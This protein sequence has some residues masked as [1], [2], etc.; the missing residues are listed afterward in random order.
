MLFSFAF[1][2]ILILGFVLISFTFIYT[3]NYE[4][5]VIAENNRFAAMIGG[6]LYS[7]MDRSYHIVEELAFNTDVKS[8]QT[9]SQTPVFVSC[10]ERNP[11]FELIYAQGMDGMQT[12]RSSGALGNRKNRWWFTQM[13]ELKKPFISESYYSV[14]TN[15]PCASVFYPITVNNEMTGIMGGDIK[16]SALQD[17]IEKSSEAGSWAFILDGKGVVAAHPKT[18]Y[19]EELYSYFKMTRTITIKNERGEPLKDEKG[20]IVTAEEPFQVSDDY[21][22]AI[23]NMTAGKSGWAKVSEEGGVIYISYLPVAMNGS[24]DPW[25]VISVK[26]YSAVT[27]QRNSIIIVIIA[28]GLVVALAS[29]VIVFLTA[30]GISIP[31][32]AVHS[33]LEKIG[34]GDL[35]GS[36][37]VKG[38]GEINDMMR[39]L[40]GARRNMSG[41]I[42]AIKETSASLLS[43]GGE[44]SKV[45]REFVMVI[46][47][48]SAGAAKALSESEEGAHSAGKT[49]SSI[50]EIIASIEA[51]SGSIEKQ[52]LTVSRSASSI[53]TFTSSISS[54]T[55]SLIR[56]EKNIENL[57]LVSEKGK[58]GLLEVSNNINEV[59]KE[60]EGLLEINAVIQTIASQT[61]LLSMNA[62]IEAAHAGESGK[63]FAVVADEIRKL[64]ES[65]S[66]QAKSVAGSLKKMREALI[67]ISNSTGNVI[68]NFNGMDKAAKTV[69]FQEKSIQEAM[70]SQETGASDISEAAESLKSVTLEV[71]MNSS[72]MLQESRKVRENGRNLENSAD[73]IRDAIGAINSGMERIQNA[74]TLIQEIT[75]KNKQNIET[76]S[77]DVSKFKI[78]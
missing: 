51:L 8:M 29:L 43:V 58:A 28:S 10:L 65:S 64:A 35:T 66:T 47:D 56:N 44:L 52:A 78:E 13:E 68:T 74:I 5:Q 71:E 6:E 16:L 26:E 14:S 18:S 2:I 25:Y 76:L 7:F 38:S 22:A 53:E 4:K 30:R 50:T 73:K 46:E 45:T 70:K 77:E 67:K 41:L 27:K 17:L 40:N 34:A 61:N 55:S 1:I 75:I 20:G 49:N 60:S 54:I 59:A 57:K 69:A 32:N 19:L 62:A 9:A 23:A 42:Q 11:Y 15:M 63:G 48:V 37:E 12:G 33:A 24:S 3:K 39:L 31:V 36:M 21:K 72:G